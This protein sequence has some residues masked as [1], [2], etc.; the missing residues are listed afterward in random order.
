MDAEGKYA[1]GAL[2]VVGNREQSAL[3]DLFR[4]NAKARIHIH[5]A[6]AHRTCGG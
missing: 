4:H 6:R 2:G 3:W 1:R 5:T